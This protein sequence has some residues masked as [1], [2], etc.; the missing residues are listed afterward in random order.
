MIY[1]NATHYQSL[2]YSSL[3]TLTHN[4]VVPEH[5][6]PGAGAISLKNC[7]LAEKDTL[8]RLYVVRLAKRLLCI[9]D[10]RA[11]PKVRQ[12]HSEHTHKASGVGQAASNTSLI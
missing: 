8:T 1:I 11:G 10:N 12:L 5:N 9:H 4:V 6:D 7:Y 2:K 3:H